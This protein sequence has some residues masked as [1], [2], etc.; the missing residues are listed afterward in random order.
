MNIMR[1]LDRPKKVTRM[2]ECPVCEAVILTEEVLRD[3]VEGALPPPEKK[4]RPPRY[5]IT[6]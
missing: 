1:T 4:R 6:K 2:K 5:I 3:R